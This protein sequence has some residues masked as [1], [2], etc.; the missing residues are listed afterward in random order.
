MYPVFADNLKN[1]A[2]SENRWMRRA[3]AVS[4]IIP[5]RKGRFHNNCLEIAGIL[6]RDGQGEMLIKLLSLVNVVN[7]KHNDQIN[8]GT[9]IRFLGEICW[10]PASQR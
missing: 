7:E 3:S 2:R 5:A 9:L 8:T 1:W 4:L 10:F 6:L